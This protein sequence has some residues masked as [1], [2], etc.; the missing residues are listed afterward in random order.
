M[1]YTMKSVEVLEKGGSRPSR[2]PTMDARGISR[3]PSMLDLF[4][5]RD[6]EE[7]WKAQ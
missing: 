4:T 1:G 5:L 2:G 3:I 6:E 7:A